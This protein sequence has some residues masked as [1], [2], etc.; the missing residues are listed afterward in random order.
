MKEKKFYE[1]Q[2]NLGNRWVAVAFFEKERHAEKYT[3][4]FNTKVNIREVKVVERVFTS[5]RSTE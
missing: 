3:E 2:Q 4:E 5:I 1:V